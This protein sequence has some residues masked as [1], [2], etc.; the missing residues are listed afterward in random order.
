MSEK[1]EEK[2]N[3][4]GTEK[5]TKVAKQQAESKTN[6]QETTK[7][8]IKSNSED[9]QLPKN[10]ET[11]QSNTKKKTTKKAQANNRFTDVIV[12]MEEETKKVEKSKGNKTEKIDSN[13]KSQ[14]S[15][16]NKKT[17][18]KEESNKKSNL[19]PIKTK[20]TKDNIELKKQEEL[21]IIEEEIKEQTKIPKEKMNKIYLKVFN[22]IMFAII[23]LIYFILINMGYNSIMPNVFVTDLK[24][25]SIT[26][27][28][29]TICVFEYAYKK[30]SGKY[31]ING[32][33]V[34]MLSICTLL[35]IQIYAIYNKKFISAVTS[36][37]L[38]FAVYYVG[39]SIVIYV[40]EKRKLKKE[41]K[42][43]YKTAK[44]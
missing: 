4:I 25:F 38:L 2:E 31:A 3:K 21:E 20:K 40:K 32:I 29:I 14:N 27:I 41:I 34:L 37:A 8:K 26:C 23:I 6:K 12:K 35:S 7:K 10:K 11:K 36:F 24:V 13:N 30:D 1:V 18:N 42:N 22:N 9:K 16:S 33:E 17:T 39:K 44:K 5:N 15:K 19:T 43:I 28:A